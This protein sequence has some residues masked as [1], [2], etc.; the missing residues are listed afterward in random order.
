MPRLLISS[1]DGKRGIY[2]ITKPMITIGRGVSNDLV[3]NDASISRLHAVLK[4]VGGDMVIA[5]REST[6]GVLLN[7][8]RITGDGVF[9]VGDRAHLGRFELRLED[10]DEARLVVENAHIPSSVQEVLKARPVVES[11]GT[12][13]DSREEVERL[14]RENYLLRVLYDAGK[15]L[16]AKLSTSDI[17]EQVMS[18]AFRLEAVERGFLLFFDEKGDVAHQSEVRYRT[19]PPA[20]QPQIILS[21]K[22]IQRIKEEVQPILIHDA[23]TDERFSESDSVRLSGLRSAICVPLASPDRL[24]ALLYV[25]NLERPSAFTQQELNVL[26]LVAAQAAAAID[27]AMTHQQLSQQA[28]QRAA[29]ER[30]LSPDVVEM[31]AAH[32]DEV[33]LGGVSKEV[34]VMFADIRGFTGLSEKMAPEK[35]VEILNGYF[36][37]VTDVIFGHEGTLDKYLGDGVMAVFGAPISRDNDARNA[38]KAAIEIQ[39]LVVQL[40]KDASSRDWPELRIGIGVNT[41]AVVAGNI[42][43]PSRLDYTVIGDAVNAA[44]RLM[45]AAKAGEV[46]ISEATANKLPAPEFHLTALE[47]LLLRG[48]TEKIGVYRV[49]WQKRAAAKKTS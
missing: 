43:S 38:V 6:N 41:G 45:A 30:F 35:V 22:I 48:K 11:T 19:S 17:A 10:P 1:P 33:R 13:L 9:S 15:A 20:E 32:P 36:T 29:L 8:Q 25:D 44:A 21:K 39:R 34:S 18:L 31:V 12:L 28:V 46:L 23:T 27:N 5:D 49:G 3:L 24:Y 4:Q 42:G 37:R 7:G 40:N 47:P 16:N 14:E 26:S 2:Y